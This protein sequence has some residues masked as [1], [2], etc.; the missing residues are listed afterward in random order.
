MLKEIKP[1]Y[2]SYYNLVHKFSSNM[3]VPLAVHGSDECL[4]EW[5]KFKKKKKYSYDNLLTIHNVNQ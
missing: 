4:R 5:F 3:H 2:V 1:I